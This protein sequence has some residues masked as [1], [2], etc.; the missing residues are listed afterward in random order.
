[1][2]NENGPGKEDIASVH[3][4]APAWDACIFTFMYSFIT[5]KEAI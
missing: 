2:Y 3:M 4:H 5:S 1:M